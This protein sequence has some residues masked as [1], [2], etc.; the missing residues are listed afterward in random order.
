MVERFSYLRQFSSALIAHL[1]FEAKG[2]RATH[3]LK[4]IELLHQMNLQQKR[5]LPDK[6]PIEFIPKKLRALVKPQG[7]LDKSA[8]EC[9]LLTSIRDEIKVGN[10][11]VKDSKRF[12]NFNNFFMPYAQWERERTAFFKRAVLPENPKEAKTY[13]TE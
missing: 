1:Q 8:W 4:A 3:L 12:G 10:L 9:A 2:E 7:L 11:M 6:A 13:L 5:K